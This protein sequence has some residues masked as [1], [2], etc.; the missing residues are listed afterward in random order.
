MNHIDIDINSNEKINYLTLQ[1]MAFLYNALEDGWKIHKI[2]NR[3]IF[4]KKHENNKEVFLDEY[5]Q[6][7][8]TKNFDINRINEL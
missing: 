8:I 5:L 2:N 1:K 4:T 3:Y 7:F 6:K